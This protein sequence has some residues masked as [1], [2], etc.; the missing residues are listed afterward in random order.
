MELLSHL[1]T[2]A[3]AALKLKEVIPTIELDLIEENI[4][5]NSKFHPPQLTDF[6][7]KHLISFKLIKELLYTV[8]GPFSSA[9][10]RSICT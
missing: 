6:D 5:K 9:E 3:R 1:K 2:C 4:L 8:P 10:D 7:H